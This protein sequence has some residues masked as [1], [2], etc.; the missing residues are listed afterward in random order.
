MKMLEL[1]HRCQYCSREMKVSD[2]SRIENPFCRH[3]LDERIAN[4]SKKLG[5]MKLVN[6]GN[7]LSFVPQ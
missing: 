7:Y 1:I 3:C 4:A 6:V 2:R 5:P